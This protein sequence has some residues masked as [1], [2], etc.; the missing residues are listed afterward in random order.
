MV[1]PRSATRSNRNATLQ[2]CRKA[3][4][5]N[6]AIPWHHNSITRKCQKCYIIQHVLQIKDNHKIIDLLQFTIQMI[7]CATVDFLSLYYSTA[8]DPGNFKKCHS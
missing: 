8:Y 7:L 3:K 5:R 1:N 2:H 6:P 4:L